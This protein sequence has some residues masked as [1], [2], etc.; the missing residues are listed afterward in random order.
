MSIAFNILFC[1]YNHFY[2][3]NIHRDQLVRLISEE[4]FNVEII[5]LGLHPYNVTIA[6]KF[7]SNAKDEDDIVLEKA[8]FDASAELYIKK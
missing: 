3:T 2:I 7:L 8:D 1:R 6:T 4:D 5:H